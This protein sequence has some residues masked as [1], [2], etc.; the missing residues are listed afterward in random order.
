MK[1]LTV[2]PRSGSCPALAVTPSMYWTTLSTQDSSSLQLLTAEFM[3][4]HDVV[5]LAW[6]MLFNSSTTY[7]L[8]V[9]SNNRSSAFINRSMPTL[10]WIYLATYKM[11]SSEGVSSFKFAFFQG[12][13]AWK[14]RPGYA[15]NILTDSASRSAPFSTLSKSISTNS[16]W[17]IGRN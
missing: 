14:S 8:E 2:K 10:R 1:Y 9:I 3:M 16:E 17:V 12:S 4:R 6:V 15:I 11:C 5:T 13:T 7:S